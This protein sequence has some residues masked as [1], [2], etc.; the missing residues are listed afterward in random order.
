MFPRANLISSRLSTDR[1]RENSPM[2]LN[3][4]TSKEIFGGSHE[5]IIIHDGLPYRLRITKN[6]KLILTK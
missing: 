3:T 5:I 2:A 1:R 6:N 4:I